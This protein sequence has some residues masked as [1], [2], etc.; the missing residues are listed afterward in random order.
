MEGLIFVY[1]VLTIACGAYSHRIALSK[2][3][4]PTPWFIAGLVLGIVGLLAIGFMETQTV[5]DEE[6][7]AR[8]ARQARKKGANSLG[9]V[10][11]VAERTREASRER[12]ERARRNDADRA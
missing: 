3:R 9:S 11:S 4:D 8:E 5:E 10:P 12:A 2:G 1:I 7:T 6:T